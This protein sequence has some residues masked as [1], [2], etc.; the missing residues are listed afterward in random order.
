MPKALI[1]SLLLLISG[2]SSLTRPTDTVS[3][4]PGL[5]AVAA[6][7]VEAGFPGVT[8]ARIEPD[9]TI[10]SGAAGLA[11]RKSG[12]AMT[13]TSLI[14]GAS[15]TK[16]VT[17]AAILLLVDRGALSLEAKLPDLL[18]P[19]DITGL[20][21][22][23]EITLRQLLLHQSGIYS[24]NNNLTYL[25]RY[26]GPERLEKPFWSPG[27]IV[28]FAADPENPPASL[29]GAGQEYSDINYVLLSMIAGRASG[30]PFKAFVG[31][32]IFA[33]LGME[34]SYFLSDQPS[35]AR[36]RGYTVDSEILRS[37]GLDAALEADNAGFID[38]TRAQE[39]SDGA[40]GIIT[41]TIDMV[42]F[43]AA[44]TRGDFLS[45]ASKA[46]VL[47]VADQARGKDGAG[48]LGVLRGYD[49]S[50]GLIVAAE[51]DGPGTNVVWALH[52]DT[53]RI[54][55]AAINQFG[56]WDENDYLLNILVPA[57]L[58]VAPPTAEE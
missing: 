49:L 34:A 12:L 18:P 7:A 53:G 44:L 20:P 1:I 54:V 25:A 6:A 28:A 51:G 24:P 17:A 13:P 22:A 47:E 14:H 2:C 30:R 31:S 58:A 19:A 40:A 42:R 57:A 23:A 15:T 21:Y 52:M 46:L 9:G 50:Y 48:A 10:L 26:I 27:E 5:D 8:I 35:R 36:T 29:P 45:P 41:T 38:T 32:D 33:P 55:A 43:A 11:D 4:L 3:R 39:Q 56:R 16:A 37:I